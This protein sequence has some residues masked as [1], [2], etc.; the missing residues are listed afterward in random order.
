MKAFTTLSIIFLAFFQ[1]AVAQNYTQTVRGRISDKETHQPVAFATIAL[2]T[3]GSLLGAISD[4]SGNYR[5]DNVPVGRAS[6]QIS[7]VGYEGVTIN[8]LEITSGRETIVNVEL[9]EGTISLQGVVIRAESSKERPLN[10][11][12]M[13]SARSFSVEEAQRFAGAAYDV[14]RLAMNFAGVKSSDDTQNEIIIRGNSPIGMIFR[15][16]GIDIPNPNHFGDGGASGGILSMLNVNTLANS[17]FITGAFPAEYSNTLSGVFDLRMRNGNN[18][19]HEFIGQVALMGLEFGA[20]GP[21]SEQSGSSYLLNYRYATSGLL[22]A[23]VDLDMAGMPTY[24]DGVFKLNFPSG[25]RGTISIIGFGGSSRIDWLESTRDTTIDK[26]EMSEFLHYDVDEYMNNRSGVIGVTHTRSLG[27]NAYLR[28]I[29]SAS[30]ILNSYRTDSVSIENR[31][32]QLSAGAAFKRTKYALRLFVNSRINTRN[33]VRM[34]VAVEKQ[35]FVLNDSIFMAS[36]NNFRTLREFN[37]SDYL[38]SPYIQWQHRINNL[39]RMNFGMNFNY[40]HSTG[41]FTPEPRFGINWEPVQGNTFSMAYGLHSLATP[42]EVL[43]KEVM[44]S[45]GSYF[46]PNSSLGMTSSHHFVMGYDR[47]LNK[48]TRV[49]TEIYYQY[50]YNAIVEIERS[51]YSMLNRRSGSDLDFGALGNNG[52]GYNYGV[53]ITAEKFMDKGSYFL[54]TLSLFESKYRGSDGVL[55]NT[56]FNGRYV[57]NMLGGKE[58]SLGSGDGRYMKRL[59]LDGKLN[60]GGG[61]R[62]SPIDLEASRLVGFTQYDHTRAFEKQMPLYMTLNLCIGMKFIGRGS[63]QEIAFGIDNITNRKNPFM[64]RYDNRIDDLKTVYQ[65]GMMPNILYR[66]LF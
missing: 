44:K 47:I 42:V 56:A 32:P 52:D 57:F 61:H 15:L 21:I 64:V 59:N 24:Q 29:T 30:S 1:L 54:S 35:N 33:N 17:D 34:G 26:S 7:F 45:D 2:Q 8:N 38:A 62:F 23:V 9:V 37:G 4:D 43:Q 65:F 58:F 5:I 16:D 27:E 41:S 13:A 55:R 18:Q 49:K 10:T 3:N 46:K 11:F 6:L 40:Q 28:V 36:E 19:K 22:D 31:M 48:T 66:V 12:A 51:S 53:E 63:T 39:V 60:I 20:E 50:L 14:S 25:T